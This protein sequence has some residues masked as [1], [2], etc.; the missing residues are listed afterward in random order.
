MRDDVRQLVLDLLREREEVVAGPQLELA[1]DEAVIR[2]SQD[3]PRRVLEDLTADGTA[4]LALPTA[5]VDD[6]STLVS[7]EHPTGHNPPLYWSLDAI[8]VELGPSGLRIR[9]PSTI[10]SGEAVR[11]IH[12]T[13][14][15]LTDL[16]DTIGTTHRAAV[17]YA[18]AAELCG[19]L[20]AHY[21]TESA[22]VIN[23]DTTEA[24]SKHRAYLS[25]ARRFRDLYAEKL[26]IDRKK[27]PRAQ[28]ASVDVDVDTRDSLGRPRIFHPYRG[29]RP[30]GS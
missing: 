17:A 3:R 24:T 22:P 9:M 2:Y 7:V 6:L 29:P 28:A 14:H 23:A 15:Q 1:L 30:V 12:T 13:A 19:Q 20:A 21:A 11:V 10:D 8:D 25:L 18:A 26:G 16:V 5:W 4:F 27:P